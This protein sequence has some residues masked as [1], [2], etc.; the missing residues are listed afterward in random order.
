MTKPPFA[1]GRCTCGAITY[2]V[3]AAPKTM[4]QC[5]CR[6]CQ[7][8]TGT[9]HVSQAFFA[10]KDVHIHGQAS[11]Y[12]TTTDGG[13]QSTRYFCPTCGSRIYG[14]NS[15]RPTTITLA[16]GCMDDHSW[17]SPKLVV[18]TKHRND[19]DITRTDIPNFN[20]M[21]PPP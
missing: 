15:G 7:K 8:S 11:A 16:V 13:N 1:S 14:L 9:G 17:F 4:V 19:W 6:D 3:T 12:T 5:H 20:E 2:T 18:Y 10:K 21:P